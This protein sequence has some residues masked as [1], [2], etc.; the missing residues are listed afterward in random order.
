MSGGNFGIA[1]PIPPDPPIVYKRPASARGRLEGTKLDFL[2]GPLAPDPTLYP[3]CYSA[4][5]ANPPPRILPNARDILERGQRGTVGIL[6]QLEGISLNSDIQPRK[7]IKDHGK[8]NVRRLREIQKKCKEKELQKEHLGPK[9]VKALWKSNKY[10]NVESK[11]KQKLQVNDKVTTHNQESL[12]FLKAHSH[13]GSG[14]QPKRSLTPRPR[15]PKFQSDISEQDFKVQ[16]TGI[17]FVAHNARNANKVKIRRSRSLQGL[18]EVLEHKQNEQKQYDSNQKGHVPQYLIDLKEK[19]LKEKEERKKRTPDPS[20]PPGHT[21]MPEAERLETLNNIKQ[22]QDQLIKELL[23]L[24]I[25]A[26]TLSIQN[27]RTEL[28][29]KLSEMEEAIKIFS[30]PKVFIKIDT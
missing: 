23:R 26:D 10:E 7:N 16:G 22:T 24:P 14:I 29:K 18:N 8:E 6:L 21:M 19:W 2:S 9:P 20:L 5:P 28:E 17:D 27:R 15:S 1:G 11:V 13:C 25:R 30:R 3:A 12:N 4:R